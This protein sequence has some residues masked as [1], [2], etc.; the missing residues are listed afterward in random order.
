MSKGL[1]IGLGLAL[2]GFLF[3]SR[4]SKSKTEMDSDI[5]TS[6]LPQEQT[7]PSQQVD[8]PAAGSYY[9]EVIEVIASID[10]DDAPDFQNR[11]LR[12]Q[13]T[14]RSF[15][16]YKELWYTYA[17]FQNGH[18]QSDAELQAEISAVAEQT[19]RLSRKPEGTKFL[20]IIYCPYWS[21]WTPY[22]TVI[23]VGKYIYV[24]SVLRNSGQQESSMHFGD[25]PI[26]TMHEIGH[27][28]G[29]AGDNILIDSAD[30]PA[31][32]SETVM[33]YMVQ[34]E[35]HIAEDELKV[36][37]NVQFNNGVPAIQYLFG[38]RNGQQIYWY[39]KY[40]NTSIPHGDYSAMWSE[41]MP[42]LE[43]I[44]N[45]SAINRNICT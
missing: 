20:M 35:P 5:D 39:H 14:L 11:L 18:I 21:Q 2:A 17:H 33:D 7:S 27:A 13:N 26:T 37:S 38:C 45:G 25:D 1:L 10:G 16:P 43:A 12:F 41:V 19:E 6:P 42:Y 24:V 22:T 23:P 30:Q 31:L 4:K 34:T 9:G 44:N 3:L 28:L 36:I 40:I 29:L 32:N 8:E 15:S